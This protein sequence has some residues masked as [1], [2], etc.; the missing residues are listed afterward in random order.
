MN[1]RHKYEEREKRIDPGQYNLDFYKEYNYEQSKYFKINHYPS[2]HKPDFFRKIYKD[3]KIFSPVSYSHNSRYTKVRT[4]KELGKSYHMTNR[5]RGVYKS[6]S[7]KTY[8]V[9]NNT[10]DRLDKISL[11]FYDTPIYWWAIAQANF[12]VDVF[13]VKRGTILRIPDLSNVQK[14]YF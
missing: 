8:I 6:D 5:L 2:E 7:D 14:M 10:E 12:L 13:N 1:V 4:L 3:V 9:D 11:I